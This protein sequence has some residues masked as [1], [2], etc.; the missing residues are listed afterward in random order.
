[1]KN[2][3]AHLL[4]QLYSIYF[5]AHVQVTMATRHPAVQAVNEAPNRPNYILNIE[6]KNQ[7]DNEAGTRFRKS[8]CSELKK[9]RWIAAG[10]PNAGRPNAQT[11][12]LYFK[13]FDNQ[14]GDVID[15]VSGDI[16]TAT[17]AARGEI[18]PNGLNDD[19]CM[20]RW[21]VSKMIAHSPEVHDLNKLF[22]LTDDCYVDDAVDTC[23]NTV[24]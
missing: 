13:R 24:E 15:A 11:S 4:K 20:L 5:V 1:L 9:L 8:I 2:F 23:K 17:A 22:S 10:R 21:V 7:P 16:Q 19:Q 14:P 18:R 3:T 12:K 6:V